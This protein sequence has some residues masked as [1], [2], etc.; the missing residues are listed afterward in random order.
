VIADTTSRARSAVTGDI[1]ERTAA[2]RRAIEVALREA[3]AVRPE[4]EVLATAGGLVGQ[5]IAR[6]VS[7]ASSR[8]QARVLDGVRTGVA[9]LEGATRTAVQQGTGLLAPDALRAVAS[10]EFL[11][12]AARLR[13]GALAQHERGLSQLATAAG[14]EADAAMARLQQVALGTPSEAPGP[15]TTPTSRPR[16]RPA[17]TREVA[18]AATDA[19]SIAQANVAAEGDAA[20][21]AAAL[22][23]K[24]QAEFE[25]YKF[26]KSLLDKTKYGAIDL[27]TPLDLGGGPYEPA[28]TGG[29]EEGAPGQGEAG[30]EGQSSPEL[31]A[32]QQ[33]TLDVAR[34]AEELAGLIGR[35][36]GVGV[37]GFVVMDQVAPVMERPAFTWRPTPD[38]WCLQVEIEDYLRK[39]ALTHGAGG[40]AVG[41]PA[42]SAVLP[43]TP[44]VTAPPPDPGSGGDEHEGPD[45]SRP[46]WS[47]VNRPSPDHD[48]DEESGQWVPRGEQGPA[49]GDRPE[50]SLMNRPSPDY[51]WDEQRQDW[52][53]RDVLEYEKRTREGYVYDAEHDTYHTPGL[54]YNRW[55]DAYAERLPDVPLEFEEEQGD[56]TK[57]YVGPGWLP[58]FQRGGWINEHLREWVNGLKVF[59]YEVKLTPADKDTK[60]WQLSY[61][62]SGE[63]SYEKV[64]KRFNDRLEYLDG[65]QDEARDAYLRMVEELDAARK[66]GDP[67]LV[68]QAERRLRQAKAQVAFINRERLG[69]A[70][71]FTSASEGGKQALDFQRRYRDWK[72]SEVL[73]EMWKVTKGIVVPDGE[74][75]VPI[76]AQALEA[77][78]RLNMTIGRNFKL[79]EEQDKTIATIKE[80]HAKFTEARRD[81]DTKTMA[82]LQ[83]L[84]IEQRQKLRDVTAKM[85]EIHQR[86]R[87][88]EAKSFAAMG[89]VG[90]MYVQMAGN[91]ETMRSLV[92]PVITHFTPK[93]GQQFKEFNILRREPP[94]PGEAAPGS[95]GVAT[96]GHADGADVPEGAAARGPGGGG[97]R[98]GGGSGGGG[99]DAGDLPE[100]AAARG[101][102]G[103]GGSGGGPRGPDSTPDGSEV[104]A[105]R[106]SSGGSR[107]SFMTE[108]ELIQ[109]QAFNDGEMTAG[110]NVRN[111]MSK[112]AGYRNLPEPRP[113]LPEEP[114]G[115]EAVL[116]VKSK[117]VS[118]QEL[119]DSV[120]HVAEDAQAKAMLKEAPPRVQAAYADRFRDFIEGPVKDAFARKLNETGFVSKDAAG[121]IGPVTRDAFTSMSGSKGNVAP[122]DLDVGFVADIVDA[123][124]G[125]PISLA[126]AQQLMNE[127]CGDLEFRAPGVYAVDAAHPGQTI[128]LQLDPAKAEIHV[129]GRVGSA[130]P[131]AYRGAV[132]PSRLLTRE[133]VQFMDRF[134]VEQAFQVSEYKRVTAGGGSP[135]VALMKK[136]RAAH[137]DFD[138]VTTPLLEQHEGAVVPADLQVV[139]D[140]ARRVAYRQCSPIRAAAEIRAR[141][142]MGVDEALSKLNGLQE[143]VVALA[144]KGSRLSPRPGTPVVPLFGPGKMPP[145]TPQEMQVATFGAPSEANLRAADYARRVAAGEDVPLAGRQL[146]RPT[147][148]EGAGSQVGS[149]QPPVSQHGSGQLP[150]P[151]PGAG[152]PPAARTGIG[153]PR[154]ASG[155]R[156]DGSH[157]PSHLKAIIVPGS[158]LDMVD[159][160]IRHAWNQVGG[161][162]EADAWHRMQ[163]I[164]QEKIGN[165]GVRFNPR[166]DMTE[167]DVA[168]WYEFIQKHPPGARGPRTMRG[169]SPVVVS[170]LGD[171]SP[172]FVPEP[173]KSTP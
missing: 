13:G 103:G 23:A 115:S 167:Q 155:L 145:L 156:P 161:G 5:S 63:Q 42:L 55:T 137:K 135:G 19:A 69:L 85:Q 149:A 12:G 62:L 26:A 35:V 157:R 37:G 134:D 16:S 93:P 139:R 170:S 14:R 120:K 28:G 48:W 49:P 77:R 112:E 7:G 86:S 98:A 89:G 144:P 96:A 10:T 124:T 47:L 36:V 136:F 92:K 140:C 66:T 107:P 151:E 61:W 59:Q 24:R 104:S 138:R 109:E 88:H 146:R 95:P 64:H 158:R 31:L 125:Q 173:P 76:M 97:R 22:A 57:P 67:F 121:K 130:H 79:F 100:G 127:A 6:G 4:T 147:G 17:P 78:D 9:S 68:E 131:E 40:P 15:A 46:A 39:H 45:P 142:G 70:A 116:T 43:P 119:A 172:D 71:R 105:G 3:G 166:Y 50:W 152:Q 159:I 18:H 87:D 108:E 53:H 150:G 153:G 11:L 65:K 8:L 83:P 141:T 21:R 2:Q 41:G 117:R 168:D 74:W 20:A 122:A 29:G 81:G 84:L 171:R 30:G 54:E 58:F 75:L 133:G 129:T 1:R 38:T 111:F 52:I 33:A 80:L 126:K 51:D 154:A 123:K 82:A 169:A 114:P 56:A 27:R 91:A 32:A 132:P 99:R 90:M 162:R 128:K 34:T 101:G 165:P 143:E 94:K 73:G 44:D 113:D 160:E 60:P 102:S 25:Q 72:G 164:L 106:A 163:A 148:G 118:P 110:Q